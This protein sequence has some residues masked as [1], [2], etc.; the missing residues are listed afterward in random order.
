MGPQIGFEIR[1][2][3]HFLKVAS[4]VF[5]NIAHSCSFEQCLTSSR[6]ETSKKK[7]WSPNWGWN[8]LFYSNVV[9]RQTCLF[10]KSLKRFCE[11]AYIKSV[12]ALELLRDIALR[13]IL[14]YYFIILFLHFLKFLY[15]GFKKQFLYFIDILFK[16]TFTQILCLRGSRWCLPSFL[17][18]QYF[19]R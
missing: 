16:K 13:N 10:L 3:C 9:K 14:F 18:F 6:A 11:N 15:R 2:F 19:Q 12:N 7:I 8:D 4:L 1:F 5:L 17:F